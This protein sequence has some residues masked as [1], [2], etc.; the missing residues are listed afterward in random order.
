MMPPL[1]L[2]S[3]PPEGAPPRLGRPGAGAMMPPR[4]LRSL[5]PAG[6]QP[7]LGPAR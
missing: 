7:R 1:S 3:L 4:S 2:R 5:P 6:A